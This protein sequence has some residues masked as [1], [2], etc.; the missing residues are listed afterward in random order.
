MLEPRPGPSSQRP[1]SWQAEFKRAPDAP[2]P[3]VPQ[4]VVGETPPPAVAPPAPA[5]PVSQVPPAIVRE[6]P[7]PVTA[8]QA[9]ARRYLRVPAIAAPAAPAAAARNLGRARRWFH[10]HPHYRRGRPCS[11]GSG[12]CA[13]RRRLVG[14]CGAEPGHAAASASPKSPSLGPR[15][16]QGS[17][18]RRPQAPVLPRA[19]RVRTAFRPMPPPW[20]MN[21]CPSWRAAR[22]ERFT[23]TSRS[24]CW[25]RSILRAMSAR[26]AWQ[27]P[28]PSAYFARLAQWKPLASG[29]SPW[30]T[31]KTR[32][33]GW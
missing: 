4:T 27:N 12:S 14:L 15:E 16:V 18:G 21:R 11:R 31:G 8:P 19:E 2:V 9:P 25:R 32:A 1:P 13:T 24:S 20:S 17:P 29:S 10:G 26:R 3:E 33:S 28:G 6:T 5:A 7:P 22:C 23:A 30:P